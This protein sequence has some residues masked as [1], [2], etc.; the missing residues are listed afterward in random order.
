MSKRVTVQN[1]PALAA[2]FVLL[3]LVLLPGCDRFLSPADRIS[4]AQKQYDAANFGA[5][6]VDAKTALESDPENPQGRLLLARLTLRTGDLAGAEQELERAAKG[7]APAVE[8]QELHYRIR[9]KQARYDDVVKEAGAETVLPPL[10]RHVLLATALTGLKRYD[11]A[12]KNVDQALELSPDDAEALLARV[13]LLWSMEQRQ[14]AS[15]AAG[16]LAAQHAEFAAGAL[17]QGQIAAALGDWK[18]AS[19]P[20]NARAS[21]GAGSSIIPSSSPRSR[22]SSKADSP[23]GTSLAPRRA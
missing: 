5:A 1:Y 21:P 6:N 23:S 2:A 15:E 14:P 4:R 19:R 9:L 7:G 3:S 18:L 10:R 16:K 11:E 13:R 17:M 22:V 20:S 8:V 12:S